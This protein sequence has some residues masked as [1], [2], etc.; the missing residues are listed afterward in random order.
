MET[1]GDSDTNLVLSS[2]D[3]SQPRCT[4]SDNI[5]DELLEDLDEYLA[6][7]NNRLTVSRMVSDSL[8]KGTVTAVTEE[9]S[10][11]LA[12]KELEVES[13]KE[14]LRL[15]ESGACETG[16]L[17]T[18]KL[19]AVVPIDP[20]ENCFLHLRKA[21]R[22]QFHILREKI[23]DV[24]LC[25]LVSGQR[26][27]EESQKWADLNETL[28]HFGNLL[29]SVWAEVDSMVC[30]SETSFCQWQ[31]R[32]F[33]DEI[34]AMVIQ[35]SIRNFQ[36]EFEV[37]LQEQRAQFCSSQITNQLAKIK[38]LSSLRQEVRSISKVLISPEMGQAPL[39]GSHGGIENLENGK[40]NDHLYRSDS[41]P[42]SRTSSIVEMNGKEEEV[43]A[44]VAET[45]DYSHLKDKSKDEIIS[46]F[47]GEMTTTRRKHESLMQEKTEQYFSLKRDMYRDKGPLYTV[48][49][50]KEFEAFRKKVPEVLVKLDNMLVE[51]EKLLLI[52]EN[53]ENICTLENRIASLLSENHHLHDKLM[54]KSKEV[55]LLLT[56]VSKAE[57]KTSNH[58]MAE[59]KLLK[60]IRKLKSE[61][62]DLRIEA[63][64]R[65]DVCKYILKDLIQK[66]TSVIEEARIIRGSTIDAKPIFT[67]DIEDS[68]M[69]SIIVQEVC[70]LIFREAAKEAVATIN[71]MKLIHEEDN[72]RRASLQ[73]LILESEK[74]LSLE[75]EEKEQ[76]KKKILKFSSLEEEKENLVLEK[77]ALLTKENER[78]EVIDQE[79]NTT[80]SK[81]EKSLKQTEIYKEKI[82]ELDQKLVEAMED[83]KVAKEEMQRL[84]EIIQE[85]ETALVFA[86]ARELDQKK[87]ADSILA[88]VQEDLKGANEEMQRLNGIIQ[89][90]ET[91]LSV[92]EARELDQKKQADSI[93]ASV[94]EDLKGANEEMQRLNGI[95]QKKET[96]LSVIKAKE[97]DQKKQAESVIASVQKF[98]NT[99]TDF[100]DRIVNIV[101][102]NNTR[103]KCVKTQMDPLTRSSSLSRQM[104]LVYK[105]ILENRYSDLQKAEAEVDLL[106]DEVDAL[107]TL[108]EKIYIALYHYSPV[109]QHYPGIME[110]LEL[111]KRELSVETA[112]DQKRMVGTSKSICS[113]HLQDSR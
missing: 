27:M 107:L 4:E 72:E 56:R 49:R 71:A 2:N 70:G 81:L 60:R 75:I 44:V 77:A 52:Q 109:L 42:I 40:R 12:L 21:S 10:E 65:E 89:E 58:S 35:N 50:D 33:R 47:K 17:E 90:K 110:I 18:P 104:E 14:R 113:P 68:D 112:Y 92:V 25:K 1:S 106:G 16:S 53:K 46:Y 80:K 24:K 66:T 32:K 9:A 85:K 100:E 95:I 73:A 87:E 30:L 69:E 43:K 29:T 38:E 99:A 76:L 37:H 97:L 61:I 7:I 51:N 5:G 79:L 3:S 22:N 28:N 11:R 15:Y 34:E 45:M 102:K 55:K 67:C 94:H 62:E 111:I 23:E 48:K 82:S 64:I 86:E 13:L 91:A 108:L 19:S 96:A 83:L 98:F 36:Q 54:H 8:I 101:E 74:A 93:L 84:L 41:N 103:L 31:E 26:K 57:E 20:A 39:N 88:S 59:A 105:Q 63:F 6:D 78:Y